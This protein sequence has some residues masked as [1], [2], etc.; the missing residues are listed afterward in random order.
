MEAGNEINTAHPALPLGCSRMCLCPEL[1]A[2]IWH[3]QWDEQCWQHFAEE[4]LCSLLPGEERQPRTRGVRDEG[5]DSPNVTWQGC[6]ALYSSLSCAKSAANW[7]LLFCVCMC[8]LTF[9]NRRVPCTA[10]PAGFLL[11]KSRSQ[12][13]TIT[14][15]CC[16]FARASVPTLLPEICKSIDLKLSKERGG[17]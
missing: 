1:W 5:T 9:W 16:A 3:R 11:E 13:R 12:A 2:H 14:L 17:C 6:A 4:L 15:T 8:V 10:V 7:A